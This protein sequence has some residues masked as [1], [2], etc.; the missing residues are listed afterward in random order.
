[1]ERLLLVLILL[2]APLFATASQSLIKEGVGDRYT[3]K[4]GDTLWKVAEY[5]LDSPWRWTELWQ[6]NP[7]IN[8]PHLIYP[9]DVVSLIYVDG[10][11]RLTVS[12]RG[13]GEEAGRTIKLSPKIRKTPINQAIPAIPL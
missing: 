6:A 12:Y 8:N 13:A 1:M 9:G 10:K 3:V 11:P 2:V 5:F 7:Q 4:K